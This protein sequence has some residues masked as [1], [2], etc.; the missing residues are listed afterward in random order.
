MGISKAA[1]V[2]FQVRRG[3][4]YGDPAGRQFELR[5]VDGASETDAAFFHT[6]IGSPTMKAGEAFRDVDFNIDGG[7][8]YTNNSSG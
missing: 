4:V 2:L 8:F 3:K 6:R 5:I 7:G 1:P